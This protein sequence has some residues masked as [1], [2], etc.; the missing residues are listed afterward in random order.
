MFHN[1]SP[2][3]RLFCFGNMFLLIH[4]HPVSMNQPWWL[5]VTWSLTTTWRVQDP[6]WG[7]HKQPS[8][9]ANDLRNFA[10]GGSCLLLTQWAASIAS[11][12]LWL[13]H[14]FKGDFAALS[15]AE[16]TVIIQN[17]KGC[18]N[19]RG[20]L[21]D[22]VVAA[23]VAKENEKEA[24]GIDKPLRRWLW[25]GRQWLPR[26]RETHHLAEWYL[27]TSQQIHMHHVCLRLSRTHTPSGNEGQVSTW[28]VATF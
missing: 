25:R 8:S 20:N 18:T 5:A 17:H 16:E 3:V 2:H 24:H 11:S 15:L 12:L 1:V 28:F 14:L 19:R 9:S 27:P 6:D 10:F 23:V 7:Q 13:G 22:T 21:A 4:C 26:L